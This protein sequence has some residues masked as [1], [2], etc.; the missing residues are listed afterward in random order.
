MP[1]RGLS[2]PCPPPGYATDEKQASEKL[3]Y[4]KPKLAMQTRQL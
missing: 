1:M 3:I 4:L 2:P